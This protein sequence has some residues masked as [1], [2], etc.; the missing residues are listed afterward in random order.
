MVESGSSVL[1]TGLKTS[2]IISKFNF[3]AQVL[4]SGSRRL[5]L[6]ILTADQKRPLLIIRSASLNLS[7]E[8]SM[9]V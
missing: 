1:Q 7:V 4:Q 6:E 5:G 9:I 8:T 2:E 3:T